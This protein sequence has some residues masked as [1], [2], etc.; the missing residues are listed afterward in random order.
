MDEEWQQLVLQAY[1]FLQGT[2]E[3]DKHGADSD[4]D[5]NPH[6][7]YLNDSEEIR[8]RAALATLLRSATPLD[9]QIRDALADLFDLKPGPR[10]KHRRLEIIGARGQPRDPIKDTAIAQRVWKLMGEGTPEPKAIID[11]GIELGIDESTIGKIW[12]RYRNLAEYL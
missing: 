9:R 7:K 11:V 1:G 4:E 2:V 10:A 6:S 12:R 8:A 5:G 3:F